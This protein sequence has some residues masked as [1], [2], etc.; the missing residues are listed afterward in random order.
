MTS[1]RTTRLKVLLF[2]TALFF[3]ICLFADN[4]AALKQRLHEA[5]LHSSLDEA[6]LKPWHLLISFKLLDAKGQSTESGTI[7]EWWA[8]PQQHKTVF[9][10]P[11]FTNT[12]LVNDQGL[13]KSVP[14]LYPPELLAVVQSQIVHPMANAS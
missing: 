13:Y 4:S 5:E 6:G 14:D 3:P 2:C 9:T 7:E 10:S 8:G 1:Q 12:E 11:S